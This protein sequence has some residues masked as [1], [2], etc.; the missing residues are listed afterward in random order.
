M[1]N[2]TVGVKL[3]EAPAESEAVGEA[4]IVGLAEGVVLGVKGA[5]TVLEGV[6][7]SVAVGV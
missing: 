3:A 1:D 4:D 2:D 6:G 5:L 7:V